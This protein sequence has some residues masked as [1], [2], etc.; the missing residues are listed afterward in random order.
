MNIKFLIILLIIF[1]YNCTPKEFEENTNA[2]S[3]ALNTVLKDTKVIIGE[4][5]TTPVDFGSPGSN[6]PVQPTLSIATEDIKSVDGLNHSLDYLPSQVSDPKF[7]IP[8]TSK[9]YNQT[10]SIVPNSIKKIDNTG[11]YSYEVLYKS[12]K[13][14]VSYQFLNQEN[15]DKKEL[16]K[17]RPADIMQMDGITSSISTLPTDA[18]IPSLP[19]FSS[20]FPKKYGLNSYTV[21][22][23]PLPNGRM[24][25]IDASTGKYEY[26]VRVTTPAAS[27]EIVVYYRFQSQTEKKCLNF[28]T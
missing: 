13:I 12:K 24:A 23:I 2:L 15:F 6:T 18:S 8:K 10:L 16:L 1:S 20:G 3:N 21:T 27:R 28:S 26:K 7:N 25:D 14:K 9:F 11:V 5:R 4:T 22:V 19:T 17:F